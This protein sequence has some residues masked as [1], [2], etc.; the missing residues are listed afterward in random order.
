[1][2]VTE[3]AGVSRRRGC[4]PY[5]A[6]AGDPGTAMTRAYRDLLDSGVAA[7][8]ALSFTPMDGG[9]RRA[10]VHNARPKRVRNW[11]FRI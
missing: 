5:E 3:L 1:V 10:C 6:H 4:R 11:G 8:Y 7:P 9:R 2:L